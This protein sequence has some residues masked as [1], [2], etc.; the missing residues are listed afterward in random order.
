MISGCKSYF[1]V[2]ILTAFLSL[3]FGLNHFSKATAPEIT[4]SNQA[5]ITPSIDS[6]QD[7]KKH[8][9]IGT[10]PTNNLVRKA[11]GYFFAEGEDLIIEGRVTDIHDMPLTDVKIVIWQ[12]NANGAYKEDTNPKDKDYDPHFLGSGTAMTNNLGEY[13][14]L[15]VMPKGY[16]TRSGRTPHLHMQISYKNLEPLRT[17]M[18]F[19]HLNNSADKKYSKL[20]PET[21]TLL[22]ADVY[23]IDSRNPLAGK[24]AV[25]NITLDTTEQFDTY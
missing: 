24:R 22:T 2:V 7:I 15:S 5:K 16:G 19:G 12:T 8:S 17:E 25:F 3:V 4:Q 6:K 10:N 18:F 21:Q 23:M 13:R 1:K 9:V 20:S 14:F 11:D